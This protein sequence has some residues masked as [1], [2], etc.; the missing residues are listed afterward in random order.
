VKPI[1]K[2]TD[3]PLVETVRA[4]L[5]SE[6]IEVVVEGDAVT[7]LP[8]IPMTVLV[9]DE[10]AALAQDLVKDLLS[11]A[12]TTGSG[13]RQRWGRLFLVAILIALLIF[14]GNLLIG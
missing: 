1:L 3:R 10:D 4:T 14:C 12:A 11:P 7:A 9:A 6:G 2:S 8:F 13:G 5:Q